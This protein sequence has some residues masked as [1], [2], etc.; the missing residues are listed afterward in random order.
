[1]L[2]VFRATFAD[3]VVVAGV[4][5]KRAGAARV[6]SAA[7]VRSATKFEANHATKYAAKYT[8]RPAANRATNHGASA[9]TAATVRDA[10]G[11][12]RDSSGRRRRPLVPVATTITDRPRD[13]NRS[14]F[15]ANRKSTR[16]N[17]SH[18][19]ISY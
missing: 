1:M 18:L 7:S 11:R 3:A 2:R 19:G 8:V 14:C 5:G 12:T 4:G 16:L 17:S 9:L 6:Q 13:I 10:A 15:L